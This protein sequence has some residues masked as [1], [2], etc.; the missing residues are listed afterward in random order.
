MLLNI[1]RD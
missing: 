1:T